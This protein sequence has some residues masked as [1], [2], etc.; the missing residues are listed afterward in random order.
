M[1]RGGNRASKGFAVFALLM[2][3]VL[4]FTSIIA[5][6]GDILGSGSEE[7]PTPDAVA[8]IER[9]E[10]AVAENPDDLAS[11]AVLAT[12]LSNQGRPAEAI[13]LFDRLVA[14]EPDNGR[15]RLAFGIALFR[16]GNPFDAEIQLKRA[17]ELQPD[18]PDAAYYLGQLFEERENPDF[19]A[20]QEWYQAAIDIAPD[21]LTADQAR[22]RLSELEADAAATVSPGP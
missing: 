5:F 21:S 2:V 20:A 15:T 9:L 16:A 1:A 19:A 18:R 17:H 10:T 13:P 14:A 3:G 11:T 4:V 7:E 22:Q 6:S 8:E 12:I